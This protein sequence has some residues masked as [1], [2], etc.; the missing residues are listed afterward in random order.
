V[1]FLRIT[2]LVLPIKAGKFLILSAACN[3]GKLQAHTRTH[4]L[5][6]VRTCGRCEA[7]QKIKMPTYK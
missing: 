4:A 3:A 5:V 1:K 7:R 6:L 2:P